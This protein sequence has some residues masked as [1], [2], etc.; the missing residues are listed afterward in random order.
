MEIAEQD[1]QNMDKRIYFLREFAQ[2]RPHLTI[3]EPYVDLEFAFINASVFDLTYRRVIGLVS[4]QGEPFQRTLMHLGQAV[5]ATA[6][7]QI[8][9]RRGEQS[10]FT[11]RQWASYTVAQRIIAEIQRT[12]IVVPNTQSIAV[13]FTY[14][15]HLG[16]Q[17]E[18]CVGIPGLPFE[19]K[20]VT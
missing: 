8:L 6:F 19:I 15:N 4:Y 10:G 5:S 18:V 20:Q 9:I 2:T 12:N 13:C 16:E 3:P 7:V 1:D 11:L 17:K 14:T